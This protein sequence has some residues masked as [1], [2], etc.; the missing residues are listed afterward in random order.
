MN[1]GVFDLRNSSLLF[2]N[3]RDLTIAI[4]KKLLDFAEG[5]LRE[6]AVAQ[7]RIAVFINGLWPKLS[8]GADG[9][10]EGAGVGL[11]LAAPCVVPSLMVCALLGLAVAVLLDVARAPRPSGRILEQP[12]VIGAPRASCTSG[13]HS[14]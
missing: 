10:F 14:S 8:Y 11:A 13:T 12:V 4:H 3:I 9:D 6:I 1:H 5:D 7:T 2:P